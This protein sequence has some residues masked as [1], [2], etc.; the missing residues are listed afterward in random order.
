LPEIENSA[1][2]PFK[3]IQGQ[4]FGAGEK[5]S[6]VYILLC[7]KIGL[8]FGDS[9]VILAERSKKSTFFKTRTHLRPP[10]QRTPANI[11]GTLVFPKTTVI[12]LHFCRR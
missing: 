12:G 7:N 6:R 1:Y 11:C 3:I 2:G 5:A 8:V 4:Y 9:E 10:I